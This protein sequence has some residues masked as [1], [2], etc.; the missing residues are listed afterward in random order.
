MAVNG[1]DPSVRRK[2]PCR[3][4]FVR[5]AQS[6]RFTGVFHNGFSVSKLILFQSSISFP[7]PDFI[8]FATFHSDATI[9]H[10]FFRPDFI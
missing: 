4:M 8:L 5:L 7:M 10:G 1:I 3:A 9:T 6:T 2:S